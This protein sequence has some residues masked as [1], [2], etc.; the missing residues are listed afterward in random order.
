MYHRFDVLAWHVREE[1]GLAAWKAVTHHRT[2]NAG[3]V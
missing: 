3:T 2:A 1:G